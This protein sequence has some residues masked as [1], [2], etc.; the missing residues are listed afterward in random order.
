MKTLKP[1]KAR[2][3]G[4]R[5]IALIIPLNLLPMA[6]VLLWDW[7]AFDLI[8]LYWM[9]NLVI[10]AFSALRMLA[11]PYQHPIDLVFP[12]SRPFLFFTT[13]RSAGATVRL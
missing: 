2:M 9:E 3:P 12:L 11:R 7:R 10:G 4:R 1:P 13:V 6:G 8:F 5:T